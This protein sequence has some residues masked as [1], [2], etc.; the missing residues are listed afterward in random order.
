MGDF[1]K[2]S[3]LELITRKITLLVEERIRW[4]V[5]VASETKKEA[6]TQGPGKSQWGWSQGY[7]KGD[8]QKHLI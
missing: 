6:I 2:A 4:S 7:S 3:V 8:E 5:A 1:P